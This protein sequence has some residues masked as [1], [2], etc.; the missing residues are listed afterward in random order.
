MRR[1]SGGGLGAVLKYLQVCLRWA[2]FDL[3]LQSGE[4][5]VVVGWWTAT[6]SSV[7]SRRTAQ[8]MGND[9]SCNFSFT[10]CYQVSPFRLIGDRESSCELGRD[11]QRPWG[12]RESF[13]DHPADGPRSDRGVQAQGC[14]CYGMACALTWQL[15]PS[16]LCIALHHLQSSVFYDQK[17]PHAVRPPAHPSV[18]FHK[19]SSKCSEP[20]CL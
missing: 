15:L 13:C 16:V 11:R 17:P 20:R 2:R 1:Q 9:A 10:G 14:T 6:N 19:W 8:R 12:A 4:W 3:A 7:G 5:V 18:P